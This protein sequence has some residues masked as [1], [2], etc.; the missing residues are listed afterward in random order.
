[1]AINIDGY[2]EV[3]GRESPTILKGY[4]LVDALSKV[5]LIFIF[6]V[7]LYNFNNF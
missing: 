1:M 3:A 4:N 2:K 6:L 5:N 7:T